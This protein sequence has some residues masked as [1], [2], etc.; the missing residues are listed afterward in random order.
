MKCSL[1]CVCLFLAA[2]ACH[3]DIREPGQP[4][5]PHRR[6]TPPPPKYIT[7]RIRF[8]GVKTFAKA[9]RF[10]V[11][12]GAYPQATRSFAPLDSAGEFNVKNA[13]R[14]ESELFLCALPR[15]LPMKK[16]GQPFDE[17]FSR[18]KPKPGTLYSKPFPIYQ[19]KPEG[20]AETDTYLTRYKVLLRDIPAT[21]RTE[22]GKK[23]TTPAA[24]RLELALVSSAW[25]LETGYLFGVPALALMGLMLRLRSS[26]GIADAG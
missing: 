12:N 9:Y 23:I 22:N 15:S 3:A 20:E 25:V 11:T 21:T 24:K 6:P 1:L 5:V 16:D 4:Y 13:P 10:F 8:E 2:T 17:Y 14:Q 7:H 19:T 26:S 18:E